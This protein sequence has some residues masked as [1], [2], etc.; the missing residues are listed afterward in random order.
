MATNKILLKGTGIQKEAV[1]AGTITPGMLVELTSAGKVQAQSTAAASSV[2]R[3]F[4]TENSLEG[5]T[6]SDDYSA[7]DTTFYE[8]VGPGVEVYAFLEAGENVAIGA[9]LEAA[10]A[11]ALQAVSTGKP[12]AVALEAVDNS[13]SGS[14]DTRIKVAIV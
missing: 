5:N 8:V 1:A 14:T 7:N 3:A 10:D 12:I 4:A 6:I 13:A 9:F 2:Q 11:G